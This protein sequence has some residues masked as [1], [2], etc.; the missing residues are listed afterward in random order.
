ML[1][2]DEADLKWYFNEAKGACGVRSPLGAQLDMLRQGT[3]PGKNERRLEPEISEAAA[4]AGCRANRIAARLRRLSSSDV[5]ALELQ[6]AAETKMGSI[7]LALASNT[8]TAKTGYKLAVRAWNKGSKKSNH[9]ATIRM[10]LLWLS[11]NASKGDEVSKRTLED[12]LHDAEKT[13]RTA[14]SRYGATK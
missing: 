12:I 5:L 2:D 9:V 13:L 10:W 11:S 4:L 3:L 14:E 7:S 6:Y 8:I 1:P